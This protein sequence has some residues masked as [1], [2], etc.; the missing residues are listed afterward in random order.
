MKATLNHLKTCDKRLKCPHPHCLSSRQI[1]SHW[2]SC[3]DADCT[4]C[5]SLRKVV[6]D[7]MNAIVTNHSWRRELLSRFQ[8]LFA[9]VRSPS[10]ISV[11]RLHQQELRRIQAE[12][13][14]PD[15]EE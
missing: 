13:K 8:W 6:P 2:K 10:L 1:L 15:V 11:Q 14:Q 4:V 9:F 3:T 5:S 7:Y 12:Q